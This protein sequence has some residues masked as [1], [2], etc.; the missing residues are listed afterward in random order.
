MEFFR[1]NIDFQG[2]Q[3]KKVGI[4]ECGNFRRGVNKTKNKSISSTFFSGGAQ[5]DAL[6]IKSRCL[7][8]ESH[9]KL[10]VVKMV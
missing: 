9:L 7:M 8:D 1:K 2:G 6:Y 5:S 3:C 10:N 4:E